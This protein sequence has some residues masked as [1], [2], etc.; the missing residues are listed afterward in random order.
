MSIGNQT[1]AIEL[2]RND[3]T[4]VLGENLD[5]GQGDT[6]SRNGTG[7]TTAL[8]ALS[9]AFYGNALTNIKKDNLINKTNGKHMVV[10]AEFEANGVLYKIERGRKPTFTK[11]YINNIEFEESAENESQGDSRETQAEIEKIL[12]M[13]HE[14]FKHILALNTYTTPF[15]SMRTNDQ[16]TIIEQLLGITKLS[17]K[18]DKLKEEIKQTKD[19]IKSEEYKI[20]GI[21][22]ANKRIKE[23]I[24]GLRRRQ[25][26]WLSKKN[27]DIEELK[28]AIDELSHVDI[29]AEFKNHELLNEYNIKKEKLDQSNKW[30][31]S[32][33]RDLQTHFRTVS[34]LEKEIADIKSH[35]CYA[36]GSDLHD[37]QQEE[38][39]GSKTEMLNDTNDLI[40]AA[41]SQL[42]AHIEEVNN[43]GDLG[44]KPVV[45]YKN[46]S[47]AQ[48]HKTSLEQLQFELDKLKDT[49]DPYDEQ[50]KEMQEVA[51]QDVDYSTLNSLT[52]LKD[53][54]EFLVKLLT[55]KDSYI[56]KRI[57]DQNMS[58]LNSRLSYYLDKM[59]LP[60]S[61]VFQNDLSVEI[62]EL[63]RD[64]DFDNLSRGERNRLILSLSWAFRDVWEGLYNTVNLLFIDE[65]IDNGLD[66][67]G[68]DNALN[69][70][71]AMARERNKSVW[72]VS[73]REELTNRV[74]N[75]LKVTKENGFTSFSDTVDVV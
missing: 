52:S 1:Q 9:Y 33:E 2:N 58:F 40:A 71:K 10:T 49:E 27:K 63:G 73:H 62:T 72:L 11:L 56:R 13:S 25:S 42:V 32:I 36:C 65:L 44:D 3:L 18:A 57:I 47:D 45:Y 23:S 46:I 64:L 7:K 24:D 8:N 68:V 74:N 31:S 35:K 30:V 75:I 22:D 20:S 34:K 50:I 29:D 38:I 14:M 51:S 41:E 4:L 61:V 39:L 55:N 15:L 5:A 70:L 54:Q 43:I 6:G 19:L 60:H 16:R 53:H 28:I 48:N 12:N 66:T 59:G 37:T 67:A 69:V 21:H 17:E 26:M